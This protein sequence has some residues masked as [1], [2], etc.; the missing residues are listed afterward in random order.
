MSNKRKINKYFENITLLV[1]LGKKLLF[2]VL[3][4]CSGAKATFYQEA[5]SMAV[6]ERSR[7]ANLISLGPLHHKLN[8]SPHWEQMFNNMAV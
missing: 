6:D 5:V 2:L 4:V 7:S 1:T 3:Q 8:I